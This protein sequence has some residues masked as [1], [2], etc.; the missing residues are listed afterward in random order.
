[1]GPRALMGCIGLLAALAACRRPAPPPEPPPFEPELPR[2]APEP[3]AE[4][5]PVRGE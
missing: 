2:A 5:A 4:P 1:M 3:S